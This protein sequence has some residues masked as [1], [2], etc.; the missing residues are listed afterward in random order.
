MSVTPGEDV[1]VAVEAHVCAALGEDSGRASVSFVGVERLDVLRFGP[2]PEGLVRYVTLGMARRPM[3]DPTATVV[4]GSGPRAELVLAVR[5]ARDSVVRTLAVLAATP[6]VEGVVVGAGATFTLG[7]PL[8]DG[9]R[10]DAVL[11]GEPG[12][13][14][15]DLALDGPEPV[16][17]LPVVPVTGDE[18][19]YKR[20]H[21]PAALAALWTAQG[22]DVTDPD[23]RSATLS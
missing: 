11:I 8:W 14:V 20:V 22:I 6:S 3:A 2:D 17:F 23:R 16:R 10:F 5:G 21:G 13:P 18:Q 1:L 19:A 7:E 4:T 9:A 15:P 12:E